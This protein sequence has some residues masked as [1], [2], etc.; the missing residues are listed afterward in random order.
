MHTHTHSY[1]APAANKLELQIFSITLFQ[2]VNDVVHEFVYEI[3]VPT[4]KISSSKKA[5]Y[6]SYRKR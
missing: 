4:R 3:A 5:L 1:L 2:N 6:S